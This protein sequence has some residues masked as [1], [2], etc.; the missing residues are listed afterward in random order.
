MNWILS[1]SK[2]AAD[3]L[4]TL[5]NSQRI[6]VLKS[7]SKALMNPLP[8]NEGGY[9]NPLGNKRSN[10]LTGCLKLK[11][12]KLGLRIVYRLKRDQN[13]MEVLAISARDDEEV[14]NIVSSRLKN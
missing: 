13:I 3:D 12:K 11:L 2:N 14:Y 5:D 8:Q 7:V 4:K 1:Y 9:G 10:N 6:Q